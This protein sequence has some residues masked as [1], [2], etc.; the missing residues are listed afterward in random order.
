MAKHNLF[1]GP[2]K[3]EEEQMSDNNPD[4][5]SIQ[6]DSISNGIN[7]DQPENKKADKPKSRKPREAT[8]TDSGVPRIF[9]QKQKSRYKC[10]KTYFHPIDA[11]TYMEYMEFSKATQPSRGDLGPYEDTEI[12][13]LVHQ[14]ICSILRRDPAFI[15]WKTKSKPTLNTSNSETLRNEQQV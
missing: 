4:T 9:R 14:E 6:T 10:I 8:R 5:I 15:Q 2:N 3:S 11:E 12:S 13:A 7:T 1:S